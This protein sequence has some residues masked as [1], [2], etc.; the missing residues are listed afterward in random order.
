MAVSSDSLRRTGST[1]LMWLLAVL[2]AAMVVFATLLIDVGAGDPDLFP[3]V[4][5][6]RVTLDAAV[7]TRLFGMFLSVVLVWWELRTR[8]APRPI[9]LAAVISGPL[10]YAVTAGLSA[11]S[12]YP[13]GEAAYYMLNPLTVAALGCQVA[14]AGVVE[15]LWR[16]GR[17]R[18]QQWSGA[19]LSGGVLSAIVCGAVVLY[20]AVLHDGGTTGF[21]LFTSGYRLLFG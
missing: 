8:A 19:I 15:A 12:Y 4:T 2:P 7:L 13:F 10:A 9:L 11:L 5:V 20:A 16:V 1:R 6:Y 3:S 21:Y 17:R 14:C 18:Q